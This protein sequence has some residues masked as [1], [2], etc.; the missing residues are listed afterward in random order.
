MLSWTWMGQASVRYRVEKP[1]S[2]DPAALMYGAVVGAWRV[3]GWGGQGSYGVVY[4]VQRVDDPGA[5][6]FALKIAL[7][8]D[9]ERLLRESELLACLDHPHVPR[10][11]DSGWWKPVDGVSF[12]F[13]VMD[14]VAGAHLY[15]WAEHHK[16]SFRQAARV[17]AQVLRALEALHAMG[18]VHRDVKGSN[19]LVTEEGRAVLTDF[20][21]GTY[22]G[23]SV[24]TRQAEPLGTPRYLSPQA[25]LHREKYWGRAQPR[26]E[27]SAA[28]DVFALGMTAWRLMT[29]TYSPPRMDP[30]EAKGDPLGGYG[31]KVS[32]EDLKGMSPEVAEAIRRMLS[33]DPAARGS[34][35]EAAQVFEAAAAK[36]ER[37]EVALQRAA[38]AA[39]VSAAQPVPVRRVVTWK[40]GL[41]AAVAGLVVALD[42][43]RPEPRRA[44]QE[45]EA[46]A[47]EARAERRPDSGTAGLAQVVLPTRVGEE[48]PHVSEQQGLRLNL[49]D[50]PLP[51]QRRPPCSKREIEINGGCW[52][53]QINMEPPCGPRIYE[54]RQGCYLPTFDPAPPPTSD[55]P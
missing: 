30:E 55:L 49:P 35:G 40:V 29:G 47:R 41:A 52:V 19:V 53:L 23:A 50:N 14:W 13:L 2:R 28:D 20:G 25:L 4:C 36:A 5:G 11:H 37:M 24:L 33:D 12:P 8:P 39:V 27:A 16:I 6:F 43:W 32:P 9:D 45:P 21:L 1:F 18:G 22:R 17:L 34:A 48:P 38:D 3:V 26:Y 31:V 42:V 51:G 44:V 54:W 46:D 7:E 15:D 10:L